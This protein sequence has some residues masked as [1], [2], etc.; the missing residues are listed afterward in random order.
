[1]FQTDCVNYVK[2]VHHYNRTHLYAC[3]TGAFHPTC[4]FVEVGHRMEVRNRQSHASKISSLF[5]L[6]PVWAQ[7]S[8]ESTLPGL[9]SKNCWQPCVPRAMGW[10]G[11]LLAYSC[12]PN[13]ER[14]H[15]VPALSPAAA[16][17]VRTTCS[18]ST[19]PRWKTAKER[20]HMILD[21]T[22]RR[23]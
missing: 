7:Y 18:G 8:T 4:A 17:P 15:E 12:C 2:I 23:C 13:L 5:G 3:G 22:Q 21:T 20:V 11:W 14:A 19:R 9:T 10:L 16:L 6:V 1:M